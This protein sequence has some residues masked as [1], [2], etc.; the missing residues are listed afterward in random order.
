MFGG[1]TFVLLGCFIVPSDFFIYLV[2]ICELGVLRGGGRGLFTGRR[3][4]FRVGIGRKG[5]VGF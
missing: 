2:Q 3:L 1:N 5:G 4:P